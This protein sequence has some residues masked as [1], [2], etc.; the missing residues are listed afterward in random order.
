MED[1]HQK[2][3][4][5]LKLEKKAFDDSLNCCF[6]KGMGL[7]NEIMSTFKEVSFGYPHFEIGILFRNSKLFN[8]ILCSIEALHYGSA[9]THLIGKLFFF[10]QGHTHSG[11]PSRL[12]DHLL[13]DGYY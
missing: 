1:S 3:I 4:T 13:S 6:N 10:D 11:A 2:E 5:A 8:G 12:E 7:I 9:C